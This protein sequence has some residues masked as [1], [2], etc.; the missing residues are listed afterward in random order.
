VPSEEAVHIQGLEFAGRAAS[1]KLVELREWIKAQSCPTA[2]DSLAAS[3]P[4]DQQGGTLISSLPNIGTCFPSS[5]F[6][7]VRLTM[8]VCSSL[9]FESPWS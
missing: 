4:E 9:S 6:Q 1:D 5:V 7:S 2:T 3:P 8:N